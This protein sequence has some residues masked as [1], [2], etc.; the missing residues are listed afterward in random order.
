MYDNKNKFLQ[1]LHE[2]FLQK[3][4]GQSI[5]QEVEGIFCNDQHLFVGQL[6]VNTSVEMRPNCFLNESFA[7]NLFYSELIDPSF[8]SMDEKDNSFKLDD[9]LQ[10]KDFFEKKKEEEK[11]KE[12]N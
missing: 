7:T 2:G 9:T 10:I 12:A 5:N 11:S 8:F 4:V 6:N 3:Y 1:E